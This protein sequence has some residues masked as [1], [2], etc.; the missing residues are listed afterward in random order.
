MARRVHPHARRSGAQAAPHR[1]VASCESLSTRRSYL[2]SFSVPSLFNG[3]PCHPSSKERY[4]AA[5]M[6]S[7]PCITFA[8]RIALPQGTSPPLST[9][10]LHKKNGCY[11]APG[12]G[13]CTKGLTLFLFFACFPAPSSEFPKGAS[14]TTCKVIDLLPTSAFYVHSALFSALSW[15][16]ASERARG[17]QKSQRKGSHGITL[18]LPGHWGR[19]RSALGLRSKTN[20]AAGYDRAHPQNYS[21]GVYR[22]FFRCCCS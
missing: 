21:T 15:E 12:T 20:A 16:R 6:A 1:R 8:L 10:C 5:P 19:G 2:S 14:R 9:R 7:Q 3:T 22:I 18:V 11:F 4:P 17:K 13:E